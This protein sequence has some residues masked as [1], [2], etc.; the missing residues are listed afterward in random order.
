[1]SG[2]PENVEEEKKVL[3]LSLNDL[4]SVRN[5]IN[6]ASRRGAFDAGE[7]EDVG[8]VY[9]KLD[10]FLKEQSRILEE[11]LEENKESVD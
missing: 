8:K 10:N 3:N 11:Q 7:F 6:I 4:A 1:M 9:N 5:I 2:V